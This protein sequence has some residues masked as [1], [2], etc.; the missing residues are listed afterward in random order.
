MT[1]PNTAERKPAPNVVLFKPLA[2]PRFDGGK[3][4][5]NPL[6]EP[7]VGNDRA[8]L[9]RGRIEGKIEGFGDWLRARNGHPLEPENREVRS[10]LLGIAESIAEYHA[11]FGGPVPSQD[12]HGLFIKT[13]CGAII[14]NEMHKFYTRVE[15]FSARGKVYSNLALV[16]E[17]VAKAY[18]ADMV[19]KLD[20]ALATHTR[21]MVAAVPKVA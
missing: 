9:V 14:E 18:A 1:V 3:L 10:Q 11:L 6:A 5:G 20:A 2:A 4:F 12:L 21:A 15:A 16:A 19:V 17:A 7:L 13:A 8:M